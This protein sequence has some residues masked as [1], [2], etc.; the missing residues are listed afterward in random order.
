[1]ANGN[2]SMPENLT[3]VNSD[4]SEFYV[5]F[6]E[7][8]DLYFS[9]SRKGGY[10]KEDIYLSKWVNNQHNLPQNLGAAINSEKSE[11]DPFISPKEDFIIFTSSGRADSFGGGDLYCSKLNSEKQWLAAAHLGETFNTNTRDYCPY[12][13]PDSRYFFYSS[14]RDVKWIDT[15]ILKIQMDKL[16]E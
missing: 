6:T 4:S 15:G 13:S 16:F 9:S 11:Y 7:K 2:W 8:G 5:S 10:G 1:L 12:I 14:A 3:N